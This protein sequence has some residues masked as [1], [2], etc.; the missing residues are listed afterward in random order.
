VRVRARAPVR[1]DRCARV[2][3]R[4]ARACDAPK[5]PPKYPRAA[6][7]KARSANGANASP[8]LEVSDVPDGFKPDRHGRCGAHWAVA[9]RCACGE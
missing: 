5:S 3:A 8:Y 1:V 9:L 4:A 7:A 2:C 6:G